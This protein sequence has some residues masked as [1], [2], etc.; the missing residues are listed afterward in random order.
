MSDEPHDLHPCV[1]LLRGLPWEATAH[2]VQAL[3]SPALLADEALDS[4][5]LPLDARA[6]P[7]GDALLSLRLRRPAA[8]LAALLHGLPL[9]S[10]RV[11]ARVAS[12]AD[13][14][15]RAAASERAL[16]RL[17]PLAPQPFVGRARAHRPAPPRGTRD[18]LV[19]C[20]G[21][22]RRVAAGAVRLDE[23]PH[24]RV[25]LMARCV[26]AAL[27]YSHGVRKAARVA[28][29]LPEWRRAL[30]VDGAAVKGLRPDERTIGEALRRALLA[31]PPLAAGGRE[32]EGRGERGGEG[33]GG[34]GGAAGEVRDAPAGWS[35]VD[36]EGA[37]LEGML[38]SLLGGDEAPQLVVLHEEGERLEKVIGAGEPRAVVLV[39][40]DATGFLRTEEEVLQR[41]NAKPASLGR[42]PL[43]ASQCIV[44]SHN[45]L[46]NAA[47]EEV[48]EEADG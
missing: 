37:S 21:V 3:V 13:A 8:A 30:R 43:L 10:R 16:A 41:F 5:L 27:F 6:R 31:A 22:P 36:G 1:L 17:A 44:I 7:S 42:L 23:L 38:A 14:S 24:G 12:A 48:A 39:I 20:H 25:D 18:L 35:V 29:L 47:A 26:C 2:E 32:A 45:V 28:L 40:G 33:G 4:L 9:R 46:D 19:L 15:R 34:E 11:D